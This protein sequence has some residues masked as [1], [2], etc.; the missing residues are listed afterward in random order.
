SK[1]RRREEARVAGF[2]CRT[3]F[4]CCEE[5]HVGTPDGQHLEDG[6][7]QGRLA[8]SYSAEKEEQTQTKE[9]GGNSRGKAS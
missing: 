9:D 6:R 4:C 2:I 5:G 1:R 3:Q 8:R 7:Q